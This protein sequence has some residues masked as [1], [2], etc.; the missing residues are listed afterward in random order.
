MK[1]RYHLTRLTGTAL[2]KSLGCFTQALTV[3]PSYAQAH[4]G[5]AMVQ[6]ISAKLSFAAPLH[7]IPMA[8]EAAL[9]A[10]AIDE[11]VAEAHFASALVRDSYEWNWA[12]A[13]REYRRA[14]DLNPGDAL[15]RC[16]YAELLCWT[17][18]ADASVAE[19]RHAIERDPLYVLARHMLAN[20]LWL[21]RRYDEAMAE[22]RAG[23]ELDP[24]YHLLYW[25][26]GWALGDLGRYDE[27]VEA[28]RQAT[29]L[30]PD[31]PSALACLGWALGLAGRR[32]EVLTIL[33]DLE[34]RR[35][36]EYFSGFLMAMVNVGL[37]ES[38]QAISWLEKAAEERDALVPWLNVW[39]PFDPLRADP[40]FQA[41]LRRMHFPETAAPTR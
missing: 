9:K 19:A 34:R 31:D 38:E 23:I 3:E 11:T 40:R 15:A 4:A 7:V 14:L 41:L 8:K 21:A 18:R 10:L 20:V 13:E 1:G 17:G 29:I 27:A 35:T 5:I 16:M 32:P 36:K 12:G 24:T 2:E 37:G 26:L 6:A 22:A 25:N 30:A 33:G 28:L 39:I